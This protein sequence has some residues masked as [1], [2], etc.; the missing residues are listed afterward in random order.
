MLEDRIARM[1]TV[2]EVLE[3]D[4]WL[5]VDDI[6]KLQIKPP[7]K[8]SLP[9]SDWK[10]R[11]LIFSVSFDGKEYYPRYQFNA[12]Y[13]PLPIICDILKAYGECAD[14]CSLAA[15]FHFP[16]GRI[17]EEVGNEAVPVAPKHALNRSSDVIKAAYNRKCAYFA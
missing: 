17:A 15:W 16:N 12:M 14:T 7:A 1:A 5:T 11:G 4:D 6:N 13:Q 2:K 3:R 9:A 8:P 10:R